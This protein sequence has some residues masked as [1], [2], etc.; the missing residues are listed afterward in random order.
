MLYIQ[1][2]FIIIE[3]GMKEEEEFAVPYMVV[4]M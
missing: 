3:Q 2:T 1:A 4:W